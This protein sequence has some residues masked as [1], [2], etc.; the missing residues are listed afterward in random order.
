VASGFEALFA[1][2]K[3]EGRIAPE[4]DI[5]TVA[6]LFMLIGDGLFWRRATDP[7][8]DG[9]LM[10]PPALKLLAKLLNPVPEPPAT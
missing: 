10:V 9:K 5:P 2:L 1:R 8:F 3:A 4:L 6:K 7:A